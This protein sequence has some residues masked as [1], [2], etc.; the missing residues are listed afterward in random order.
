MRQL[1]CLPFVLL[2][3]A[4][5]ARADDVFHMPEGLRSLEFVEVGDPGNAADDTGF[6]AVGYPFRIGKTEV[7]AAQWVAF[8]NTKAKAIKSWAPE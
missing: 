2:L 5:S 7:T 8:L 4:A 6:G 1:A 3:A